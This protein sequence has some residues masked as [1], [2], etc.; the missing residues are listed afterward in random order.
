VV[1]RAGA[2]ALLIGIDFDNTLVS[3]DRLFIEEATASGWI[4]GAARATKKD[5]RDA[6]RAVGDDGDVLWQKLQA[7]VYGHRM[8]DAELM[9][10][11]G[12]F[13]RRC[14]AR[15][16]PVVIVSHKTQHAPYDPYR[17]DLR[18][19]ALAW[20]EDTGFF[21]REGFA[22]PRGNVYFEAT[23]L[24]KIARIAQCG[25]SDFIDDLEEVFR[26][27]AF[28]QAVRRHLFAPQDGPLPSGPFTAYRSWSEIADAIF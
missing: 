2:T 20:M 22:L 7:R 12:D 14:R 28:P 3:Y 18:Q 6:V 11:A 17:A 8:A 24:E 9:E 27:D 16:V 13:L 23:R 21:D 15:E 1:R 5:V 4:S 25:C 26:E 10:G 19:A